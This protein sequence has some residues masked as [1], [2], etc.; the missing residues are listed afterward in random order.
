FRVASVPVGTCHL[1]AGR[2]EPHY[3]ALPVHR[4]ARP[5]AEEPPSPEHRMRLAQRRQSGDELEKAGM[6][7][8]GVPVDPGDLI[9][10]AVTVV[11]A[12]LGAP[13]FVAGEQHRNALAEKER[14]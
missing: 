13:E 6:L 11:V 5:P 14:D 7:D 8:C 2:G 12:A 1:R 10:L 4:A 9:V 3:V